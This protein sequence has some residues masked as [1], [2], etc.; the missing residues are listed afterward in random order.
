[1]R[2]AMFIVCCAIWGSTWIAIKIG[3]EIVPPITAAAC[4]FLIAGTM[5]VAILYFKKLSFPPTWK[6]RFALAYPGIYTYALTYTL[7]YSAE[8]YISSA[9]TAIIFGSYPLFIALISWTHL[10]EERL[11]P[12]GWLGLAAGFI[13]IVLIS[14]NSMTE[15]KEILLGTV[16]ALGATI[17]SAYGTV[18]H[19]RCFSQKPIVV[20]AASQIILGGIP[21]LIYA[22]L[23]EDVASIVWTPVAIGT[24]LYLAIFGTVVAFLAYYWLLARTKAITVSLIAFVTPLVAILIGVG[25]FGESL[26]LAAIVGTALI[27]SGI[28]L[29]IRK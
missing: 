20:S 17:A 9:L 19:K 28:R 29:V 27:F 23:V 12:R 6:E 22:L 5:L 16:L 10:K 24:I 21:V 2:I 25:F 14:Y 18:L 3:V 13:G 4:R 11:A 8:Q 1:M 15:S 26:A 7:V